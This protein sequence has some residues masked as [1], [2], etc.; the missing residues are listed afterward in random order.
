MV[1][2]QPADAMRK[3][4]EANMP[5]DENALRQLAQ[6]RADAVHNFLQGKIDDKRLF[7]LAPKLDAKG[8]ED[9]GKTT[10]VDFSLH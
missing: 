8:I 2:S 6:S 4:L 1:K 3:L 5:V 7:L 10:R 9:Q